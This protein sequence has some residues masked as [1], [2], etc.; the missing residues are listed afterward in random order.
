LRIFHKAYARQLYHA[1]H[2]AEVIAILDPWIDE[3]LYPG[4]PFLRQVASYFLRPYGRSSSPRFF[5]NLVGSEI[6]RLNEL[7]DLKSSINLAIVISYR[8][9]KPYYSDQSRVTW[10]SWRIP[11]EVSKLVTWR[12]VHPIEPCEECFLPLEIEEFNRV[13]EIKRQIGIISKDLCLE[14]Q[15]KYYYLQKVKDKNATFK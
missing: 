5:K 3:I 13:F 2:L 14:K 10:M 7:E 9:Y 11:Y 4:S 6:L 15:Y 12:V 1:S 8:D